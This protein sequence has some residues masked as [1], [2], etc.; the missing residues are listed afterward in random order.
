YPHVTT[1]LTTLAKW[2]IKLGLLT[3]APPKQA[4]LRLCY[5]NLHHLFDAVVTS[6]EVG[7]SKPSPRGFTMILQALGVK[8]H[9]TLMVGDWPER[10]IQGA[11]SVGI[12]TVFA[13]YGD[14]PIQGPSGADWEID[15]IAQLLTIIQNIN[16][17]EGQIDK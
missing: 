8:A 2:G 14:R 1:T 10:D 7:E 16:R 9:Q 5:L 15:D 13:R 11:Q 12:R 3:D 6:T 4:W 17:Q